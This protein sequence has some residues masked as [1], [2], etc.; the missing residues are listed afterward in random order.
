MFERVRKGEFGASLMLPV[1]HGSVLTQKKK[2]A[3]HRRTTCSPSSPWLP[4]QGGRLRTRSARAWRCSAKPRTQTAA[5]TLLTLL[6][7]LEAEGRS[8]FHLLVGLD[9]IRRSRRVKEVLDWEQRGAIDDDLLFEGP[10]R[11]EFAGGDTR[12]PL[13]TYAAAAG[14][15]EKGNSAGLCPRAR[16]LRVSRR[17]RAC[18]GQSAWVLR[19]QTRMSGHIN[20]I[21]VPRSRRISTK[22]GG[23]SGW[24]ISQGGSGCSAA[25]DG[26]RGRRGSSSR[27]CSRVPGRPEGMSSRRRPHWLPLARTI[28]P[29]DS[30]PESADGEAAGIVIRRLSLDHLGWLPTLEHVASGGILPSSL[31]TG[32][33]R[34]AGSSPRQTSAQTRSRQLAGRAG[35]VLELGAVAGHEPWVE[36]R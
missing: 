6:E 23:D 29:P 14:R 35:V 10:H 26:C 4:S 8:R 11:G 7:Q 1:L 27:R 24:S 28:A 30:P 16:R 36:R 25:S 17:T 9:R 5:R 13:D 34:S 2:K 12:G 32:R 20:R 33:Y 22:S 15:S 18:C 21:P 19:R 3:I 31:D